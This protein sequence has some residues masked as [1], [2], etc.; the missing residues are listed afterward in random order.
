[1]S[2][3]HSPTYTPEQRE[4][5]IRRYELGQSQVQIAEATKVKKSTVDAWI[6]AHRRGKKTEDH[7]TSEPLDVQA[8]GYVNRISVLLH[9]ALGEVELSGKQVDPSKLE[10]LLK[11]AV[12]LDKH[13]RLGKPPEDKPK[14]K[15]DA[16]AADLPPDDDS[17]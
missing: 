5:V 11:V 6:Q 14:S 4:D 15:M 8:A 7:D 9:R 1:M 3:R 12:D 2:G 17:Q 13:A 10:K 16:L